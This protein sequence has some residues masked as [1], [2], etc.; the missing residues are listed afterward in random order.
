MVF[1]VNKISYNTDDI[2]YINTAYKVMGYY[3]VEIYFKSKKKPLV[4]EYGNK[5]KYDS[6]V[7]N[8]KSKISVV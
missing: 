7:A 3:V 1:T 6:V 2:L 8:L 5:T 4:L